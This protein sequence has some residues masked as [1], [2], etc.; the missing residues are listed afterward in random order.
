MD[1]TTPV[2]EDKEDTMPPAINK[3]VEKVESIKAAITD[4]ENAATEEERRAVLEAARIIVA[5]ELPRRQPPRAPPEVSRSVQRLV[6]EGL[7]LLEEDYKNDAK[8]P[9]FASLFASVMNSKK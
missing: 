6:D 2:Q 1:A 3:K 9:R 5:S 7:P 8:E 4:V